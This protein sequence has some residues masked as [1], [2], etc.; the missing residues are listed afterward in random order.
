M[1]APETSKFFIDLHGVLAFEEPFN[2]NGSQA[3]RVQFKVEGVFRAL[4]HRSNGQVCHGYG[5]S[6]KPYRKFIRTKS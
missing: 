1:N 4:V 5:F 2:V 3:G 6:F